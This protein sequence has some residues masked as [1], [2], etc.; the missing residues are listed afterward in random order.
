MK[1][2]VGQSLMMTHFT[3]NFRVVSMSGVV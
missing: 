3:Y 2:I 1:S